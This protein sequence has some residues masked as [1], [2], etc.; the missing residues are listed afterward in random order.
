[1][2]LAN[3]NQAMKVKL[4]RQNLN[5]VVAGVRH[6]HRAI[7]R[8]ANLARHAELQRPFAGTADDSRRQTG[9]HAVRVDR[10][11]AAERVGYQQRAAIARH[12]HAVAP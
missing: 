9:A 12:R 6:K 1:M 3:A 7:L 10:V 2:D 8:D 5:A 11:R 4:R